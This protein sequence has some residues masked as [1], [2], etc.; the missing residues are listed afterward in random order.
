MA[1]LSLPGPSLWLAVSVEARVENGTTAS[2][3]FSD[4][5]FT[6]EVRLWCW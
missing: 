1:V 5:D 2:K 4:R 3:R 6:K